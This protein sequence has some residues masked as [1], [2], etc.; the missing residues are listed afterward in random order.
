MSL[1]LSKR[2]FQVW[3]DLATT[4]TAGG[5]A[6]VTACVYC[7]PATGASRPWQGGAGQWPG[8]L[9]CPSPAPPCGSEM[10]LV[11]L[12]HCPAR[13]EG[14]AEADVSFCVPPR[15]SRGPSDIWPAR[16]ADALPLGICALCTVA[17]GFLAGPCAGRA[18]RAWQCCGGL[19]VTAGEGIVLWRGVGAAVGP[20]Q[21]LVSGQAPPLATRLCAACTPAS[22]VGAHMHTP[23]FSELRV[24]VLVSVCFCCY[25]V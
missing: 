7:L 18:L 24:C 23:L 11:I 19:S 4:V 17:G 8:V 21:T 1:P 22:F 25:P 14:A 5:G 2:P 6:T 9:P 13:P 15:A 12:S 16:A 10:P 3:P 20:A